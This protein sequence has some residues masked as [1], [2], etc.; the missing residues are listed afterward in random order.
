[1]AS[2]SDGQPEPPR[3]RPDP[4]SVG[5]PAFDALGLWT[6]QSVLEDLERWEHLRRSAAAVVQRLAAHGRTTVVKGCK[7]AGNRGWRRSPLGGNGGMQFYLWWTVHGNGQTDGMDGLQAGDMVLRAIRHHDDHRPLA[8]GRPDDYLHDQRPPAIEED[9]GSPWTDAQLAFVDDTH[10]V[11]VL[12]GQPGSGKTTA[13]WKAVE[14]RAGQRVLYLTWSRELTEQ[15]RERFSAFAP[16]DVEVR[17]QDFL[18]FLGEVCGRDVVRQSADV[19]RRRFSNALALARIG[20]ARLGPWRGRDEALFAEVRAAMVGAAVPGESRGAKAGLPLLSERLYRERRSSALGD[21]AA[22]QV[23]RIVAGMDADMLGNAF[24]ELGAASEAVGRLRAGSVPEGYRNFDRIV[25]D[26]VQDLTLLE[27]SVVLELCLAIAHNRSSPP[28]LLL[29]GDDGQTVRP[30]GFAWGPLSDLLAGRL[31]P[32]RKF[33]LEGNLRCPARIADVIDRASRRYRHLSK[34]KRPTRQRRHAGGGGGGGTSMRSSSTSRCPLAKRPSH[35]CVACRRW[36]PSRSYRPMPNRRHGCP[37][38]CA[39]RYSAR[40]TRRGWS[41][42]QCACW[43]RDVFWRASTGSTE[44]PAPQH[45]W[46]N[47]FD[48]P[49]STGFGLP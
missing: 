46:K 2:D 31:A 7:G 25:V 44:R 30:S 49:R 20:A 22:G 48:A 17:T 5:T 14:A 43:S 8:A 28:A 45:P 29:A 27:M 4:K 23:P 18:S 36:T 21:E 6:H 34:R 15:A 32:P 1:M 39:E 9:I 42:R 33:D 26:E 47:I 35:S 41:T 37:R 19:S 38:H 12:L 10:P 11:R 3:T 13:L 24:P 40:R 16:R